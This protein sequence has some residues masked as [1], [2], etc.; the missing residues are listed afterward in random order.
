MFYW[1]FKVYVK[2]SAFPLPVLGFLYSLLVSQLS[3]VEF[4][5]YSYIL[6]TCDL[7]YHNNFI[8]TKP[9]CV[10][11]ATFL[12]FCVSCIFSVA[13]LICI[14]LYWLNVFVVSHQVGSFLSLFFF[15]IFLFTVPLFLCSHPSVTVL[16]LICTCFLDSYGQVHLP[17]YCYGLPAFYHYT[18]LF[19]CLS[20]YLVL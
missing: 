3:F 2:S 18:N 6:L 1:L 9:I 20:W 16:S 8:L 12:V 7:H 4:P 10:L 13:R 14:L 17:F 5:S 11:F 15:S 19:R